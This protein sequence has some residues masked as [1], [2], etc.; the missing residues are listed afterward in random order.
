MRLGVRRLT[1]S[2]LISS[3]DSCVIVMVA[4]LLIT[5]YWE[6]IRYLDIGTESD[7][8]EEEHSHEEGISHFSCVPHNDIMSIISWPTIVTKRS[9]REEARDPSANENEKN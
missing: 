1:A 8:V 2:Y 7:C 9:L 4:L 3:L 6:D 5:D